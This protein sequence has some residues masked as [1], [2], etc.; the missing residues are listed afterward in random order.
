MNLKNFAQL[1][2]RQLK[3][4]STSDFLQLS[5]NRHK[6][7]GPALLGIWLFSF[8]HNAI[9]PLNYRTTAVTKLEHFPPARN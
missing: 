1:P 7:P 8:L 3:R 4:I 2:S 5:A 6:Q 9:K